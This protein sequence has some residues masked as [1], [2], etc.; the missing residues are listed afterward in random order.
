VLGRWEMLSPNKLC[1]ISSCQ[2]AFLCSSQGPSTLTCMG[3]F[4]PCP[5]FHYSVQLLCHIQCGMPE[6][7]NL[8]QGLPLVHPLPPQ[9]PPSEVSGF[10]QPDAHPG[11]SGKHLAVLPTSTCPE[12]RNSGQTQA[13][14]LPTSSPTPKAPHGCGGG[15][16][17]QV[18]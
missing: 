5:L 17:E 10:I 4:S 14:S 9:P 8:I 18:E 2:K 6:T 7:E 12:H 1:L 13:L 15:R 16:R 3:T 11:P